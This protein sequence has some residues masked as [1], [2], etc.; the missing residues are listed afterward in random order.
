MGLLAPVLFIVPFQLSESWGRPWNQLFPSLPMAM[1]GH[2][3]WPSLAHG[4][5]AGHSP[6]KEGVLSRAAADVQQKLLTSTSP[7]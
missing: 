6:G 2:R 3:P 4:G 5:A 1:T 7:N